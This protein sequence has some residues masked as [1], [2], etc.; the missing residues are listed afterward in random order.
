MNPNN[1]FTQENYEELC[2]EIWH[3]NK[4]YYVKHAPVISDFEFDALLQKLESIEREHPD[5]VTSSSPSQRVGEML[6]DGFLS[7]KHIIPMLSLSNTYNRDE[8]KEFI[9]RVQKLLHREVITFTCELKMDGIAVSVRY[10]HGEFLRAVTRG[11]GKQGDDITSNIRTLKNLPL[12][13]M[14]KDI[15]DVLEVRGEVFMPHLIFEELNNRREKFGEQLWA[16]PR[17]AAAGSLKLL[18]PKEVAKRGLRVF[19]Y[20]VAEDSADIISSQS[21]THQYLQSVGLPTL[22]YHKTCQSIQE[23]WDFIEEIQEIRSNLPYDIDGV[24]I[25]VDALQEQQKVGYTAKS[26]RWAVA[27]KF[28]AE[29]ATTVVNEITVQVGRTGVLTPVAELIPVFLAGSTIS[30]ATLHNEEEVVRKD[31][32]VGDTV[33]IEKGG[34]VIPKVVKVDFDKRIEGSSPWAMP[35]KCPSCGS[36]VERIS[37][38]VAVRCPNIAGCSDQLLRRISYFVAKKAMNIDMLGDKIVEQLVGVGYV[39]KPSDIYTL[40]ANQLYQLEGFQEKSVSNLLKSI[41]SSKNVPLPQFIMALGIKYVGAGTAELLALKAGSLENL[42]KLTRSELLFIDGVGDK[43]ADAVIEY[44]GD[45]ENVEEIRRLLDLGVSP[46]VLEIVDHGDH[47]FKG[48]TFVLTGTL[49]R[50]SRTDAANLIKERGGK[51]TG[52]VSKKTDYLLAGEA[53]GSKL[54]KAEGL[55]VEVLSE[56]DFIGFL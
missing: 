46:E 52:S 53:A 15:P 50:Y 24:V 16:N 36:E 38:E 35:D 5:W 45:Q 48:K 23:I 51:V 49:D 11:D 13:L 39:K 28:A 22:E 14:G 31:I 7:V 56:K 20:G 26:P 55:G 33:V 4:L 3:H 54:V 32:R 10:E 44:F 40:T 8:I 17:N 25:K 37:G 2:E 18:D 42:M 21:E 43:V 29:Q 41:E 12:R 34:D 30:R 6:T 1:Q 9:A 47:P 19:F 27:Y